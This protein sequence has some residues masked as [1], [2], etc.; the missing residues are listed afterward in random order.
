PYSQL[1]DTE[2]TPDLVNAER[3]V[4]VFNRFPGLFYRLVRDNDYVWKAACLILRG[5][6]NYSDIDRRLGILKHVLALF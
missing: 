4:R 3:F 6:R 1:L 2:V 5:E